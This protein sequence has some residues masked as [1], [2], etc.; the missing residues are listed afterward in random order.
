MWIAAVA[1]LAAASSASSETAYVGYPNSIAVIGHSGST[2]EDSDP[3][4]PHVEIRA[5][6]WATGTNPKVN[7][8]YR[9]ILAKNPKIKGHNYGLSQAGANVQQVLLQARQAMSMNPKPELVIVQVIDHDIVC[10]ATKKDY[11]A[12]RVRVVAVLKELARGPTSR[13]F[14]VSQFGS[15]GTYAKALTRAQRLAIAGSGPCDFINDA[16]KVVPA[17]AAR[18]DKVIH[19][20]EA[21]LAV[22]CK[23][24]SKCRYDGGAFGRIVD[25]PAYITEDLN[26]FSVRGH[27]KAAAV[28]WAALKRVGFVPR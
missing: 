21:Q 22:A 28:A 1:A 12:F 11:A 4:Q 23:P 13:V 16:G 3:R 8:V 18:L 7:S 9:R 6:S 19:A 25:K 24:F 20:Y 15:P 2:G 17:K 14:L 27:A 5:N 10:P 26:H